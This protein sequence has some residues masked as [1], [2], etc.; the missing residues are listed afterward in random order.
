[1]SLPTSAIAALNSHRRSQN[2]R[3]ISSDRTIG[4]GFDLRE[5]RRRAI[6]AGLDFCGRV[7]DA[8]PTAAAERHEPPLSAPPAY[9]TSA[10]QRPS[11]SRRSARLGHGSIRTTQEIY[12][13]LIHGQDDEAARRW[14]EFQGRSLADKR[15][16]V[17]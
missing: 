1:M 11:A 10:R 9:V 17:Q 2:S 4:S 12:S 8:S 15:A 16:E 6:E 14:E 5:S 3:G 7:A 13:R